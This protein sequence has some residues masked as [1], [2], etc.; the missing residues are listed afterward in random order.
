MLRRQQAE[1]IIA[2]RVLRKHGYTVHDAGDPLD[3]IEIARRLGGRIDLLLT[4][5]IMPRMG[6]RDLAHALCAEFPA[7]RVL[8]T[9]GYTADAMGR[10]G[11]LD[12]GVHFLPKPYVPSVLAKKVREVLDAKRE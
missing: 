3:A 4:D 7:L 1:A 2:A 8:Y 12:P 6:G 11:E 9:S 5:V 10:Q